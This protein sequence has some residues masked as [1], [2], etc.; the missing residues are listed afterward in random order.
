MAS[1]HV[2][3]VEDEPL[4]AMAMELLVHD[5]DGVAVGPF[6]T[7]KQAL[8]ALQSEILSDR[9]RLRTHVT[10]RHAVSHDDRRPSLTRET[11]THQHHETT[12]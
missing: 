8:G 10:S 1:L 11:N 7:V 6:S 2:M 9:R 4:V 3:I 5:V 12:T